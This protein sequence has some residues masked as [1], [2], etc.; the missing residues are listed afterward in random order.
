MSDFFNSIMNDIQ[1][2]EEQELGPDYQYYKYIN[3]PGQMGMSDH[4]DLGTLA[5]DVNGLI[6]YVQLLVEGN[7]KASKTG[8]A[9]GNKFFL[10]TGAQCTAPDNSLQDRYIYINNV[11]NGNIPFISSG[12]GVDFTE[13]K[14][15]IPGAMEDLNT[16][17]PYGIMQAFLAGSNPPCQLL[18][19]ETVDV[20][21]TH[22]SQTQYVTIDDIKRMDACDFTVAPMSGAP[23]RVNPVNPSSKCVE[24]FTTLS[25][26]KTAL[27]PASVSDADENFPSDPLVQMYFICLSVLGILLLYKIASR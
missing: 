3:T 27:Q 25:D 9:L 12:L 1:H 11:P 19:M 14:G 13:F 23:T 4:G 18:T 7:G 6:A 10:K 15:L 8:Q 22:G 21:N 17:S 20:N 2:L 24:A 26:K 16:L 5:T